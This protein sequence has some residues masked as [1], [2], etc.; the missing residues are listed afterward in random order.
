M[1]KDRLRVLFCDHLNLAR[2]KYLP[3]SQIGSGESRFCQGIYALTYDKE[4]LPAP[5]SG[6]LDGLPDMIAR[7][8]TAEIRQ[9][10]HGSD[11]VVIADQFD[12][13]GN[14][15]PV[16]GRSLLKRTVGQWNELGYHPKVGIELEAYA[17]VQIEDDSWR[18]S[19]TPGAFVYGTGPFAD[20]NGIMDAIWEAAELSGFR[21]EMITAEFDSPQFEFT[22]RYDDAIA[23]ID[24]TFLFRL[25]A[26]EIALEHGVL[27]TFMPKPIPELAGSGVHVN[28]SLTNE[29]GINMIGDANADDN[30][31]PLARS[32]VAGLMH[33]H[34][35][36]AA[37][38]AP[39][40][41]SYARLEPASLSG[42]WRN[43]GGDHRGV[44]TR[45][46]SETGAHAR[47]E[48]RMADG[49]ANPYTI[50]ASVLQAA[51]LGLENQYP[52]PPAET[53]DCLENHDATDGVAEDLATALADLQA[54]SELVSAVGEDLVGN[55]VTIKENEI[56]KTSN[57]KQD[58]L[59]DFYIYY[60]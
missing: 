13:S 22:L 16:C 12:S 18:P 33:H 59:R 37:L 4:L 42:F 21:L 28:F 10:W 5:C 8:D 47:I 31:T 36:L 54:D 11:Q 14:T 46:T 29:K 30:M 24:D 45:I 41:N 9:G 6:L 38:L 23:A 51:R 34:K 27:L 7:Y 55:L 3:P 60:I 40:V 50:V 17:F 2:G 15:L 49:A 43:W 35:G 52:L 1:S 25:M 39:T 20:P 58:T 32:C 19:D 48:H 44:T 53:A 56:E 26:R 57:L